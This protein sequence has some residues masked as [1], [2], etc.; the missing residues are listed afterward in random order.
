MISLSNR[1][2]MLARALERD[3]QRRKAQRVE[4]SALSK[5]GMVVT[6][7]QNYVNFAKQKHASN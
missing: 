6:E 4:P 1:K 2:Q 5:D 3:Q 7:E